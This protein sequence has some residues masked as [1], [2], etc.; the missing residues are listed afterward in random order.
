MCSYVKQ[1][2]N[3]IFPRIYH[4]LGFSETKNIHLITF[5]HKINYYSYNK[6]D[7]LN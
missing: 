2:L 5:D 7:F 6:N 3:N 1:I 4:K